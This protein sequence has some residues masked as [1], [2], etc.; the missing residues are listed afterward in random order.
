MKKIVFSILLL[1]V[2]S[3]INVKAQVAIGTYADPHP[4]AV[5]DLNTTNLGLL[6]SRVALDV[7]PEVFVL[8]GIEANDVAGK[9]AAAGMIVYN[10]EDNVQD[11]T[12][13]YFWDG[14]KWTKLGSKKWAKNGM[15]SSCSPFMFT[16]Q[17]MLLSIT[18]SGEGEAPTSYK[19]YCDN[20]EIGTTSVPSYTLSSQAP[21]IHQYTCKFSNGSDTKTTSAKTIQVFQGTLGSLYPVI[22]DTNDGGTIEV[23]HVSLGAE[24]YESPC[25]M[26]PSYYQW[27]RMADGHEVYGSDVVVV[28]ADD[29]G[30]PTTP[31]IV[32]GKF[33][34]TELDAWTTAELPATW[35]NPA[36]PAGWHIMTLA[37]A[38]SILPS[39]EWSSDYSN[40]G[41]PNSVTFTDADNATQG[42]CFTIQPQSDS[43]K[44]ALLI[45]NKGYRKHDGDYGLVPRWWIADYGVAGYQSLDWN[46]ASNI[47]EAPG[48]VGGGNQDGSIATETVIIQNSMILGAHEV[49]CVKSFNPVN[50][51]VNLTTSSTTIAEESPLVLVAETPVSGSFEWEIDYND[52]NGF[53]SLETTTIPT[54]TING[55]VIGEYS[56]RVNVI[57]GSITKTSNVLNIEVVDRTKAL[58]DKTWRMVIQYPEFDVDTIPLDIIECLISNYGSIDN[59]KLLNTY[60]YAYD[61]VGSLFFHFDDEGHYWVAH[62][63]E[64]EPSFAYWR[65]A[66]ETKT[67]WYYCAGEECESQEFTSPFVYFDFQGN[68]LYVREPMDLNQCSGEAFKVPNLMH[69]VKADDVTP[70]TFNPNPA[71]PLRST[72]GS[73]NRSSGGIFGIRK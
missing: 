58:T 30:S 62:D 43:N 63:G 70:P 12:G 42:D 41:L 55:L 9:A 57:N 72:I 53:V 44:P 28:Q 47:A 67:T 6:L 23:A 45:V 59:Y 29:M 17:E 18:L 32:N 19:W 13:M 16:Y 65:W 50:F 34:A 1:T 25:D 11:G 66:D 24:H 35:T 21:G 14:T 71:P 54:Y 36:C 52:T 31:S 51:S 49:R 2:L 64:W 10:T 20:V 69:F 56:V 40:S 8:D 46:T 37:E 38:K 48:F 73:P 61:G 68:N 27:G 5:L 4:A 39:G 22:L 15:I 33:I 7:D 3:I 60:E 26:L